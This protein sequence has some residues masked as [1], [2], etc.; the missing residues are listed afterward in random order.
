LKAVRSLTLIRS[1]L[2]P[3]TTLIS[4]LW[5]ATL[6]REPRED[7]RLLSWLKSLKSKATNA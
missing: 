6:R 3:K 7:V 5:S 4:R 2:C 1:Q